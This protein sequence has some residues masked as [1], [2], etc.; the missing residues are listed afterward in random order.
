LKPTTPIR[1][2]SAYT[3]RIRDRLVPLRKT[4]VDGVKFY[5]TRGNEP[6]DP[7]GLGKTYEMHRELDGMS[8]EKAID[9]GAHIGSYTLRMAKKFTRVIAFEPNPLN[10]HI[11]KLNLQ[12]NK[13]RNVDVEDAALSDTN[14]VGR[15][16][17]Q[18]TTGGT[19][20]LNPHHYGFTYD[21]TIQVK[22][23]KLD[24]FEISEVDVL[25]I[26]AEGNELH[27]LRGAS[28]TINRARPIIAVEV[29]HSKNLLGA[30]CH[31]ET[32]EYLSSLNYHVRL[33]GEYTPTPVHWVLAGPIDRETMA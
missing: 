1:I 9:V 8:G 12:L 7:Q 29:H 28:Q 22:V 19:S 20:S 11:L 3:N 15:F 27:I 10:R 33:L 5:Y 4:E 25:K 18:R 21:R 31:C 24:D 26:D 30:T 6:Q 2:V 13:M 32:C 16:F 14:G 17:V 23:R